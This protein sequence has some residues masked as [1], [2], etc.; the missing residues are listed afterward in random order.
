MLNL[1]KLLWAIVLGA[2][3]EADSCCGKLR[4]A[5]LILTTASQLAAL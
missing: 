4:Q 2:A 3:H 5:R 1:D